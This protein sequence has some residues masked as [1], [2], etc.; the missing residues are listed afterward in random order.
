MTAF[1]VQGTLYE[2]LRVEQAASAKEI[3][4]AYYR[5]ARM[6]HPDKTSRPDAEQRFKA[7][8]EAYQTLSDPLLRSKAERTFF[9]IVHI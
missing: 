9:L 3:R 6:W 7:V 2:V 5:E 8:S 1:P 4:D